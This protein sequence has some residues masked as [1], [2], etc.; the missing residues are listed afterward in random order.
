MGR[1]ERRAAERLERREASEYAQWIV[2]RE[3]VKNAAI[4]KLSR[5]GITPEDLEK[6]YEKGYSAGF[7]ESG[8]G[9]L[10][11]TFAAVCLSLKELHG[12]GPK[13]CAD[14]LNAVDRHLTYSLTSADLI[15]EVW[16]KVGLKLEFHE[17]FD[18]IQE[19]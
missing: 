12:F 16:E 10:R 19:L 3:A 8:E 4:A 13:R 6:E 5:N 1:A 14:V 17:P 15:D 11:G 2:K 9:V 7:R 18:R